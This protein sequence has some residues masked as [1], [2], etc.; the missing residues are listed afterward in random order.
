MNVLMIVAIL[1][2]PLIAVQ[3]TRNS[4]RR[5]AEH[6][7][8]TWVYKNLMSSRA[9]PVSQPHVE[10]LNSIDLEFAGKS[11]KE[12]RVREDWKAYL[13]V[14]GDKTIP[15]EIWNEKRID[16]LAKLLSSMGKCL[17]YKFDEVHLRK[18]AYLPQLHGEIINSQVEIHRWLIAL[19]NGQEAVPIKIVAVPQPAQDDS[20]DRKAA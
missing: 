12:E 18:G 19:K 16:R 8:K 10:A 2:A 5:R 4:D 3:V 17:G 13:D 11:D 9:T 7:R 6:D 1:L 15:P 14:L 20:N